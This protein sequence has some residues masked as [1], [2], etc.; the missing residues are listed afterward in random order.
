MKKGMSHRGFGH[1]KHLLPKGSKSKVC[2][3]HLNNKQVNVE[4]Q[5]WR[6]SMTYLDTLF[7]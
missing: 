3:L 5:V 6:H 7:I 2:A 1:S 4:L